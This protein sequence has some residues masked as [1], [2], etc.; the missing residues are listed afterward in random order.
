MDIID[1]SSMSGKSRDSKK[2][3][4]RNHGVRSRIGILHVRAELQCSEHELS[5][6]PRQPRTYWLGQRDGERSVLW[7]CRC[8]TLFA[9]ACIGMRGHPMELGHQR[10]VSI[11]PRIWRKS[12]GYCA[13]ISCARFKCDFRVLIQLCK[14]QRNVDAK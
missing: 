7:E 12:Q 10:E 3:Q 11:G 2:S 9:S 4:A 6:H 1:Q 8:Y 5:R 13:N 14:G